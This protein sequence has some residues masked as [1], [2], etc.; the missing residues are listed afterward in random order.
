ME[1]KNKLDE[2]RDRA[3]D[4][5]VVGLHSRYTSEDIDRQLTA[6]CE[7]LRHWEATTSMNTVYG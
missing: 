7:I 2:A 3:I 5:L 4:R 1:D 6:A